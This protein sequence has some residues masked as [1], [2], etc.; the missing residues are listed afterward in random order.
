MTNHLE[1]TVAVVVAA[2]LAML[3]V[4]Q[5]ADPASL[6]IPPTAIAWAGVLSAGLGVVASFLPSVRRP[7]SGLH[8]TNDS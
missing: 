2:L 5:V 3:G 7:P 8:E 6:G 1:Y 4:V